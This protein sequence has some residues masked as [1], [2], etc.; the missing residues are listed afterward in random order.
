M[1]SL[2]DSMAELL[3]QTKRWPPIDQITVDHPA[4]ARIRAEMAKVYAA[5]QTANHAAMIADH[6]AKW[7]RAS[8]RKH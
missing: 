7:G 8:P 2:N 1:P 4:I 3:A 5:I 6:E